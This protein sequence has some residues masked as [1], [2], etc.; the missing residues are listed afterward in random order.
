VLRCLLPVLLLPLL[1][2]AAAF[3]VIAAFAIGKL[4]RHHAH[5]L[6]PLPLGACCFCHN[7]VHTGVVAF[8]FGF[9]L[10]LVF[11]RPLAQLLR[12]EL[13]CS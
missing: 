1:L 4:C 11:R 12:T 8:S 2:L 6:H 9:G 3:A 7:D 5:R 13:A 10:G